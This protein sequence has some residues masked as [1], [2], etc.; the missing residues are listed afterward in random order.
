MTH[1][2]YNGLGIPDDLLIKLHNFYTCER[3]HKLSANI[4]TLQHGD[5]IQ[6]Q[7]WGQT[8]PYEVSEVKLLLNQKIDKVFTHEECDWFTLLTCEG[9][10]LYNHH[11]GT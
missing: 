5:T 2:L 8:Y 9:Y 6:I 7:A 4:K 3:W 10:I 11:R 1:C